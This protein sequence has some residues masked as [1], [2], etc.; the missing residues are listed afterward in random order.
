MYVNLS[1][2]AWSFARN[3]NMKNCPKWPDLSSD[4]RFLHVTYMLCS[5]VQE[6][7]NFQAHVFS[8]PRHRHPPSRNGPAKNSAGPAWPSPHPSWTFPLLP[9]QMDCGHFCSLWLV[10][11]KNK[12]LTML[13]FTVQSIGHRPLHS[14]TILD[15]DNRMAAQ[16]LPRDLVRSI[17]G[18]EELAHT[19]KKKH[20][21]LWKE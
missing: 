19:M 20:F 10:A 1:C 11:Q 14:L 16:H 4:R 18:L 17:C 7:Q 2:K 6:A 13:S 9:T 8:K 21:H 3:S 12:P 15:D 5:V